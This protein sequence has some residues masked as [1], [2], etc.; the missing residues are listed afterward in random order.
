M[1]AN[2]EVTPKLQN[3]VI[4]GIVHNTPSNPHKEIQMLIL[5]QN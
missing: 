2:S 5:A 3:G 4:P 1:T